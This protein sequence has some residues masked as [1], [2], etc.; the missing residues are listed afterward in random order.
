MAASFVAERLEK[1]PIIHP[2]LPGLEGEAGGNINGPSLIRVPD[3]VNQPLGRYYLYFAHHQGQY[4][5]LAYA[6]RLEGPWRIHAPG[7]LR[8]EDGPGRAHIASPDVH[9]DEKARCIRMYF[10]MPAVEKGGGQVS[11]LALSENG[12]DFSV[13]SEVL[14]KSYFRVFSHE[15]HYYAL[16]KY[17][18]V[19][20]V[21]Y[22]SADGLGGFVEGARLMP[23]VRHTALLPE[24]ETLHV[25]FSR[26]GDA[27]EA[28]LHTAFDLRQDWR[29]WGPG[30]ESPLL[31]PETDWEGAEL[32]IEASRPGAMHRPVRQLRDPAVFVEGDRLYL[33]YSVAGEQG[34]AIANLVRQEA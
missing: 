20:G 12:L 33:L 16:A 22:R 28:I 24:G 21:L 11:F 26:I 15:G 25:F 29:A 14:G 9:V 3:W 13:Q 8:V 31:E 4:I 30:P 32:A 23:Q 10:H 6:D 18:N 7:V 5:R 1:N 17:D 27:P 2:G 19:D 34:I